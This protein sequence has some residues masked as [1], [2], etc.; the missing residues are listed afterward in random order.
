MTSRNIWRTGINVFTIHLIGEEIQVVF[1]YK[2]T[3]LVHFTT[4]IEI[5][6]RVVRITDQDGLGAFIDQLLKLFHLR[7]G[8]TFFDG[9]GNGTDNRTRRNGKSHIVG[10]GRFRHDDFIPRIQATQ[11]SEQYRFRATGSDD[12]I[13]GIQIDVVFLVIT[14]QLFTIALITL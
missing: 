9:S 5:T 11:E 12:D 13:V 1:L 3:N 14:H 8:E 10:I 4:G 2:V 6:G 7:K